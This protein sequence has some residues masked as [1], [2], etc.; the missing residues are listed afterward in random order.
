MFALAYF[1]FYTTLQY[2]VSTY[3]SIIVFEHVYTIQI[4]T[5]YHL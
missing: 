5:I 1:H 3:G 4:L 2:Y